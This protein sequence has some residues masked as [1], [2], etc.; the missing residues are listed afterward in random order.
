M[1]EHQSR[2]LSTVTRRRVLA[3]LGSVGA[4]GVAGCA[5]GGD[6]PEG[7]YDVGMTAVAYDPTEITVSVGD[8]VV[9]ANTSSRGHTVTA[10]DS[11]IPDEA[12]F[13]ASGGYDSTEAARDA[14][15]SE[16]GGLIDSG[17]TWSHTFEVAGEYEYVCLPHEASGMVGTVVVKE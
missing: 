5:G 16:L 14:F 11:G 17:D 2:D 3:A 9:W 8:T 15:G 1:T 10:Y 13:F 6:S 12:A 4:V 7:D